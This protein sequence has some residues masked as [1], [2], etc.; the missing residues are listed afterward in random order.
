M[1][2]CDQAV[3]A[4]RTAPVR[5]LPVPQLWVGL[6][7]AA[8]H[9]FAFGKVLSGEFL[10]RG[11]RGC[12]ELRLSRPSLWGAASE[13][14]GFKVTWVRLFRSAGSTEFQAYLRHAFPAAATGGGPEGGGDVVLGNASA[15]P[16]WTSAYWEGRRVPHL[17][18]VDRDE[19]PPAAPP[20]AWR[21]FPLELPHGSMGGAPIGR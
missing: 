12:S 17:L 21:L 15:F 3:P 4:P 14:L 2:L 20:P 6:T 13:A 18:S 7:E 10:V 5:P 16:Q 9:P 11:Y 19:T 8:P 1:P